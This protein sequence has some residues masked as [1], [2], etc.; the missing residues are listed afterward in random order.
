MTLWGWAVGWP[1]NS[2]LIVSTFSLNGPLYTDGRENNFIFTGD[3]IYSATGVALGSSPI[4]T[5]DSLQFM[6]SDL[7]FANSNST[8]ISTATGAAVWASA[9]L[10]AVLT[11]ANP[12]QALPAS[13]FAGSAVVFLSG[14]LVVAQPY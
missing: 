1:T 12:V 8:I 10:P 14:N 6:S 7:A 3:E 2:S 5:Y 4:G 9:D 13:V 11:I